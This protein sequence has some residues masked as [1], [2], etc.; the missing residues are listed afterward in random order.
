MHLVDHARA[1]IERTYRRPPLERA[2]R[3]ALARVLPYPGRFRAALRG[4]AAGAAVRG[5][6]AAAGAGDA[7]AGA[8]AAAGGG[9]AGAPRVFAGGGGAAEAGGAA[10]R[11][12]AA[13]ARSGDQRG[14]DPAA[15][16]ARLRGGGGGGRGLLRGADASHGQGAARAM[17]RRRR[18]S[19]PGCARCGGERARRGGGQHL[20]LRHHG[21][22][23]WP[24][25]RGRAAGGG[26]GAGRGAGAGRERA[27]G[28]A[29][30][31]AGGGAPRLR[32]AYH[33][34]CSLQHGQQV[35]AQPKALLEGRG[36]RGG[37][38]AR[39]PSLLRLGRDLQPAAAGDLRASS[40]RARWR[41]WRRRRR[42]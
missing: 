38:A 30:A 13:G 17:P 14:D 11:L 8:G 24:Y 15:D 28:R 1:H 40:G 21:E 31:R 10:G 35:R 18:T 7:G 2:L 34:A 42:R 32:V 33:A 22:G 9:R 29:R 36:V 39:Q 6:D 3:W 20:G 4:G 12:R 25:V 27:D 41:R 37:R 26:R 23:L 5:A 16:P 19:A